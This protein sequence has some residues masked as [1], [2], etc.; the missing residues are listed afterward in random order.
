MR[1]GSSLA[2][3]SL[4]SFEA[5]ASS[6]PSRS[7]FDWP[8]DVSSSP[9]PRPPE[10]RAELR[11]DS[12]PSGPD[13][14]GG[15]SGAAFSAEGLVSAYTA[16]VEDGV[17]QKAG[18]EIGAGA[19][20][21]TLTAGPPDAQGLRTVSLSTDG[22]G[23]AIQVSGRFTSD[24]ELLEGSGQS[25]GA[26]L[27]VSRSLSASLGVTSLAHAY[28]GLAVAERAQP[29]GLMGSA[30][31]VVAFF[32][33]R[34]T[35]DMPASGVADYAGAFEGVDVKMIPG[36]SFRGATEIEGDASLRVDFGKQAFSGRI[37]NVRARGEPAKKADFGIAMRGSLQGSAFAGAAVLTRPGTTAPLFNVAQAGTTQG[38]FFGPGAAE[39]AGVLSAFARS[40]DAS[41]L[42]AGVFGAKQR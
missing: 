19:R 13:P 1:T 14:G 29:S 42:V 26:R 30:G 37:D 25:E 4:A 24:G 17:T 9:A 33:G 18:G 27:R 39:A 38:A 15:A 8:A 23:P 11:E 6:G 34:R 41:R 32:G 3:P 16:Q 12:P 10:L 21:L 20:A 36:Q 31:D 28:V 5:S 22:E 35:Q 2:S 40:G 7:V